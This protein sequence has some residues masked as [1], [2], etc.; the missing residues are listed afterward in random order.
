MVVCSKPR[1]RK[2]RRAASRIRS[3]V[4][5]AL[6]V[7]IARRMGVTLSPDAFL[8]SSAHP[9]AEISRG[10]APMRKFERESLLEQTLRHDAPALE[11]ELRLGPRQPRADLHHP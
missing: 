8:P 6:A 1:S 5:S 4:S 10:F 11:H 3:R 2:S 7:A 9:C